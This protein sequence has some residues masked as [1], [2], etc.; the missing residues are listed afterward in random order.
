MKLVENRMEMLG[1]ASGSPEPGV[2][3]CNEV[4]FLI[5]SDG[6]WL[7]KGAPIAH[8]S[9]VCLL[10]S[11]L[12]RDA[13]GRYLL[14]SPAERRQID[15]EDAPL[16]VVGMRWRGAGRKQELS[17]LTNTDV[18]IKAGL[19]H[20]LRVECSILRPEPT[21]YLHVRDGQG[22]FPVEARL[23]RST[24]CELMA[25][26]EPGLANGHEVLGVWSG[27][28]FFKIDCLSPKGTNFF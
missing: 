20:E 6:R 22:E 13:G 25:L 3:T 23:S 21:L 18:C 1:Y 28:V 14:E 19:A 24:Y 26:A 12:T 27:G 10:A 11:L 9:M 17:F 7:Y 4:P 16:V 15:V 8:K 2:A 5:K